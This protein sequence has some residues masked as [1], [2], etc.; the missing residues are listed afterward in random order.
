MHPALAGV[1]FDC[2]ILVLS[3]HK[4]VL[5]IYFVNL[6]TYTHIHLV[7]LVLQPKVILFRHRINGNIF[8]VLFRL[9][10]EAYFTFISAIF[11]LAIFL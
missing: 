11:H 2:V 4:L 8:S 5:F 9:K 6:H 7:I 1:S 3:I 10:F